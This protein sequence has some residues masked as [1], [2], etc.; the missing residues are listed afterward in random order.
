MSLLKKL[1]S[2]TAIY[3]VSY[4]LG[5]VLNYI[6]LG[7]YLTHKVNE[8]DFAIYNDLYFYVALILIFLTF[9]METTYFRFSKN[10]D[11]ITTFT[12]SQVIILTLV[13]IWLILS[14]GW[15]ASIA[16]FLQY[17]GQSRYIE[18]LAAIIALDAIIAVPFA[19]LRME[20]R[21][22][23]FGLLKLG[24]IL[25]NIGM[26]I[27]FLEILPRLS[28]SGHEWVNVYYHPDDPILDVF[29]ANLI[30]S[31]MA[32][33]VMIP[34]YVS[35]RIKKVNDSIFRM[36]K[37]AF[38]L[39]LVGI[40]GVVNQSSYI[41][42]QKYNLVGDLSENLATAGVYAAAFK[43]ALMLSLFTT[44]FNFAAEPFFFQ[45]SD[46]KD[47]R[48]IY[49]DVAK[50]Y[51]IFASL[52]ILVIM[53][54]ID[55]IPMVLGKNF[56]SGMEV[57]PIL[58]MAFFFLGLYYNFSIW[59]KITDRT[60]FGTYIALM[61]M[62][63]TIGLSIVLLPIMGE[64]GSAWTALGCY[65]TMAMAA[66]F[67]G[68]KYYPIEYPI[69]QMLI[70]PIAALGLYYIAGYINFK[71]DSGQ[72]LTFGINSLLILGFLWTLM[73]YEGKWL[74]TALLRT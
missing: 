5:R 50:A 20:N 40:A 58:L 43:I 10:N 31:A 16:S 14:L 29:I 25:I 13:T 42:L 37:Y 68:K 45:N 34:S 7:F 65:M 36:M 15:S 3:G 8:M 61:G 51:A 19:K 32:F 56:R 67:L 54:Y 53:M 48:Q 60:R 69:I 27:I 66:L 64:I 62:F 46:R 70:Y 28:T 33:L 41:T 6:A 35:F 30:S 39:V 24:Q 22:V 52:I 49:A 57:A 4:I 44:G 23:K 26:V 63:V 74:K 11:S 73:K 2:D 12:S 17:P 9:R 72:G 38:P 47:T 71:L 59:Y 55:W 18:V 1:A 21:P